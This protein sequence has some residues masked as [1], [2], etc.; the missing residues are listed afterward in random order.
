LLTGGKRRRIIAV[1]KPTL[2]GASGAFGILLGWLLVAMPL[3]M[4]ATLLGVFREG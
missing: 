4:Q 1:I 2:P 3:L